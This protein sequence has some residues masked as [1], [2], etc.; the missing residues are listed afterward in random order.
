MASPAVQ[1]AVPSVVST[2]LND[3]SPMKTTQEGIGHFSALQYKAATN[4]D[5]FVSE[6]AG[7]N[8]GPVE[9]DLFMKELMDI[10]KRRL[11]TKKI[12]SVKYD[13]MFD[14]PRR[15]ED[16]YGP[17]VRVVRRSVFSVL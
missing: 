9:P 11:P 10:G 7:R 6:M 13:A 5:Q 2:S 14:S 16:M 3:T 17:M 8:V 4:N 1:P 12:K 15:E